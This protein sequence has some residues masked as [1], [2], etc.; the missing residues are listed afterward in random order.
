MRLHTLVPILVAL[1]HC[2]HAAG[3]EDNTPG[4]KYYVDRTCTDRGDVWTQRIQQA[5]DMAKGALD[6]L[7]SDQD[8]DFAT[9]YEQIMKSKKQD[10][11]AR[12]TYVKGGSAHT[13]IYVASFS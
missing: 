3:P 7:N 10:D 11:Q 2:S 6:R 12:L 4:K 1:L 9:I 5:F 13:L 8:T